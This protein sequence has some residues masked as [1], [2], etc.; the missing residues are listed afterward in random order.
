ME[1]PSPRSW[2][3]STFVSFAPIT[4][5]RFNEPSF[6]YLFFMA[7]Q[8]HVLRQFVW[9]VIFSYLRSPIIGR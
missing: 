1:I 3:V 7:E 5:G 2:V 6:G 9:T 4:C 8:P